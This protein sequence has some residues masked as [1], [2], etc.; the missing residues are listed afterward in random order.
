MLNKRI[1][2]TLAAALAVLAV[3]AIKV[4]DLPA[5][6]SGQK[7]N[8]L[9][10]QVYQP[11][12][13][14]VRQ[15]DSG[16]VIGFSDSNNTFSWLG[17][18]Y[19]QPPVGRL[20]WRAPQP[21]QPWSQQLP[22]LTTTTAC[23]QPWSFLSAE[24]GEL[25]DVVGSEDCLY[26]NVTAPRQLTASA[27]DTKLPVM[28]WI[29]G[30]ANTVGSAR[31]YRGHNIA[32]DQQVVFVSIN[33]RLGP[34]G[35]FSHSSLRNTSANLEDAS[36]N[37]ALL[38]II[39]A[40]QW[41]QANIH[42]FGGNADKVT[43]FGESAGGR[44][45]FGLLASPLA[46]GLFHQAISQ[47]GSTRTETT[48]RAENFIDEQQPGWPNSSN[49][50][51]AQ[52]QINQK[53]ANDR[54]EAK[55]DLSSMADKA[56]AALLRQQTPEMLINASMQ[57]MGEPAVL[58]IPQ[59]FRD[60][61]VLPRLSMAELFS[62][63]GSYNAVPMIMGAN[64]DEEKSLMARDPEFT[65]RQFGLRPTIKD[66]ARY[67]RY[68]SYYSQRWHMFGG[69]QIALLMGAANPDIRIY[70]YRFDWDESPSNWMVDM[71]TLVG[72]GHGTEL[73]F[74]FND[75]IG[76]LKLPFE[77]SQ[78]S[79]PG[80]HALAKAMTNYW[81]RFAH[82]GSPDRGLFQQQPEWTTW[83]A[84]G[85]NTMILDSPEGGGWRMEH[86]NPTPEELVQ[87]IEADSTITSQK[88]R[89]RLFVESFLVSQHSSDF[90]DRERY[91][92]LAGGGCSDHDPYQFVDLL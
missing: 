47:S 82:S 55:I 51:L 25:G 79:K 35:W 87:R 42:T 23:A 6:N 54:D 10:A 68:A 81:G 70:S 88:E 4:Y 49:E 57:L 33:Y 39:A 28:L 72:A 38:D 17:I 44:N 8:A 2:S 85:A 50:I 34:L 9:T 56:I 21:I 31:F 19:A 61:H 73:N 76:G 58:R 83:Q 75:F 62:Q 74:V 52:L 48:A 46:K 24:I 92:N 11:D 69:N 29:H 59:L 13:A 3:I 77:Y 90:W 5:N 40:L 66:H 65:R 89:C 86:Y 20:R 63:A 30:G 22:T 7:D 1:S 64:R 18:P 14:T 12:P 80:R 91:N 37:Y 15:T 36:G 45:I 71:P 16:E 84:T 26:L 32:A 43:I 78:A 53:T 41:V 60:G 27:Q 67:E